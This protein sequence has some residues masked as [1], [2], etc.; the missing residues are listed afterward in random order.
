MGY[1]KK[2]VVK[3]SK[4]QISSKLAER[5]EIGI[6][7]VSGRE[8]TNWQN[9]K[10]GA[11][12]TQLPTRLKYTF[13]LNKKVRF[14][15]VLLSNN[16]EGFLAFNATDHTLTVFDH[17]GELI[18]N[19]YTFNQIT[20][21]NYKNI[22]I[23]QNQ[24]LVLLCTG[25]NPI[26]RI[27]IE[28][29]PT[30][31][32]EVF[33]IP[34]SSILKA[35]NITEPSYNPALYRMGDEGLPTDPLALGVESGDYVY[36]NS[37]TADPNTSFPWTVSRFEG[38]AY[39]VTSATIDSIGEDYAV[40][41]II[42]AN[43]VEFTITSIGV[44]ASLTIN[45]PSEVY[46][47]DPSGT[48]LS[49]NGGSGT[50]MLITITTTSVARWTSTTW[51]PNELDLIKDVWN[52]TIWQFS[53]NVWF[54]PSLPASDT[55][56]STTWK[57][58]AT[59]G[60]IK[61]TGSLLMTITAPAGIDPKKYA[62]SIL[63]GVEFDG[64]NAIG[65]MLITGV[66][67]TVS[68]QN[69]NITALTGTT[70]ITFDQTAVTT[71]QTGF[72]V[73]LSQVKV[74]DG[75]YPNTDNNPSSSTN[76]PTRILF[77][78]QRLIIAGTRYN[79]SQFIFS[80]IAKYDNF[81]D[82]RRDDSAFQLVLGSTTKEQIK[83]VVL[84]N[85]IQ[86][87]TSTAEWI[88]N[89][90][91]ITR[92]S[93]FVRNSTIGTNGVQPIIAANG[94]TLFPPKN[95]KGIIGFAY[96]YETASFMTPYIT[97][98][99]D[100]LDDEITDMMLKRGLDSNDDTLIYICDI[101]GEMIIGNYLQEHEIQAFSSR[102]SSLAVFRQVIQCEQD[103]LFLAERN[104]VTTLEII[105]ES[106]KTALA[107]PVIN[108]NSNTGVLNIPYQQY[109]N[110]NINIYDE[111][112]DFVGSYLVTNNQVVIPEDKKPNSISEAGFNIHSVFMSNPQN[113]GNET[114]SLFK[115]INTI[116]LAVTPESRTEFLK[117]NGKYGR[118]EGDLVIYI[119]PT[120]PLKECIY[121]IEN[122]NYPVEILSI[123]IEM[124]A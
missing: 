99:T 84:N 72:T 85:G 101:N 69:Y 123:E 49:V 18:S 23:A 121:T 93:G 96:N 1:Y 6:L 59:S 92:T 33:S 116:K 110:Q 41:D 75:D 55:H 91:N 29:L 61:V 73:K 119:R 70:V 44:D 32:A 43:G 105:D 94:V 45:D 86:I 8:L 3:V 71:N 42:T 22:Q 122:D 40:N 27:H 35:A 100:L 7:D 11:I 111:S 46:T 52:N 50:G 104:G 62:E 24:D 14:E 89:D 36:P 20:E 102:K 74:F 2:K 118:R 80:Q 68:G 107:I 66:T 98:F 30:V 79:L 76:F 106:K 39:T 38:M 67:G 115:T 103:V 51:T 77:Y 57:I 63:I 108:Y 47:S 10:Y 83:S 64:E 88:M 90:Q 60:V 97:L 54:K 114:L 13:G 12:K 48:Q 117:V 5:T 16:L 87:F 21:N 4:G 15:K 26:F 109:A 9:S 56:Y 31:T 81:I 113:I 124:E 19:V 112:G 37:G 58:N 120:R 17:T 28:N 53:N 25:D 65:I 95:G 82:E 78:Q 34:A